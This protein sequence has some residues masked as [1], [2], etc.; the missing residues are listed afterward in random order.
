MTLLCANANTSG[1][2]NTSVSLQIFLWFL[3][4]RKFNYF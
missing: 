3:Y 4:F 1:T 2:T